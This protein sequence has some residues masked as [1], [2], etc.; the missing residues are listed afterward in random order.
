MVLLPPDCYGYARRCVF[1]SFLLSNSRKSSI[2][3]KPTSYGLS[4]IEISAD[5]SL[6]LTFSELL[7][8][9]LSLNPNWKERGLNIFLL[10]LKNRSRF[11][12]VSDDDDGGK[13][14][15]AEGMRA[16]GEK[17]ADQFEMIWGERQARHWGLK[18]IK[19]V[20]DR[21]RMSEGIRSLWEIQWFKNDSITW[22][23]LFLLRSPFC[24]S[25]SPRR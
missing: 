20:L 12:R 13:R 7:L 25:L 9:L 10:S 17:T 21:T 3:I 22:G 15:E 16:G 14:E 18:P 23:S 5:P 6:T 8:L 4:R 1:F 2:N 11:I 19:R 24:V